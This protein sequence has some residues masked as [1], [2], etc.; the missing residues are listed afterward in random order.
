MLKIRLITSFILIIFIVGILFFF[1]LTEFAW[2]AWIICSLSFWEWRILAGLSSN[3]YKIC[4]IITCMLL[5]LFIMIIFV[6]NY[7][8]DAVW[9]FNYSMHVAFVWWIIAFFLILFYPYSSIFWRNFSTIRLL[10]GILTIIPFLESVLILRKYQYDI[11]FYIGAYRVLYIMV[12]VWS[13]DSGSYIFG[14]IFG[15]YK[16]VS[17]ISPNKTWEGLLGGILTSSIVCYLF[18]KNITLNIPPFTLLMCSLLAILGSILGDLFESMLKRIVKIKDS[19]NFI[20]GHGGLLDRMDS[21]FA[22]FPLFVYLMLLILN[23]I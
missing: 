17:K 15:Y 1:S 14:R 23:D 18:Y 3:F 21:L 9:L 13:V 2:S 20:P 5:S 7:P 4:W 16:L 12:L 8:F 6:F 22:A 10:F 19:S 11:D